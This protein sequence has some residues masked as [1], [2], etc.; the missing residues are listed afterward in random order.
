MK[1][2]PLSRIE[3]ELHDIRRVQVERVP[4]HFNAKA[5]IGALFGSLFFG[6]SFALKGL[7]LQVTRNFTA[8]HV[9]FIGAAIVFILTLEIYFI[10]YSYVQNRKQRPFGQFWFKRIATYVVVGFVVATFLVYLYGIN[11]IAD[12]SVHVKNI[13]VA[14]AFPCCIGASIADLIKRY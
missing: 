7:L 5:V 10:G 6:V 4:R 13:I 1:K 12:S 11:N 2:S 8:N 9:W 3:R 14:L